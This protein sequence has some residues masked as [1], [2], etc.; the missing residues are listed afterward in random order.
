MN[1]AKLEYAEAALNFYRAET[2]FMHARMEMDEA[3]RAFDWAAANLR[4]E[5]ADEQ[6]ADTQGVDFFAEREQP[7][8]AED[9][10]TR[11][12]LNHGNVFP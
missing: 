9:W 4:G 7:S 1:K 12:G 11:M 10:R 8:E 5:V 6:P 2:V 3:R